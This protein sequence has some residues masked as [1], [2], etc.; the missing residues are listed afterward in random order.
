SMRGAPS[1]GVTG[2]EEAVIAE[3]GHD[4]HLISSH[5][6]ERV[7]DMLRAAIGGADTVAI[8]PEVCDYHVVSAGEGAGDLVPA[9]MRLRVAMEQ[10]KRLPRAAVPEDNIGAISANPPGFKPLEQAAVGRQW[11]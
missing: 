6:A 7:V 3:G 1:P 2:Q 4:V 11:G 10:K 8:T 5:S 9:G